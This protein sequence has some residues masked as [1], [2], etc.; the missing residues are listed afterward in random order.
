MRRLVVLVLTR[1]ADTAV[2]ALAAASREVEF[3]IGETAEAVAHAAPKAEAV[4]FQSG[5]SALLDCVL[6]MAPL[7]RWV[8]AAF[9]G[10]DRILSPYFVAHPAR[11]T[12]TR[13]VFG[14]ALAEFALGSMLYFAKDFA[15]MRKNQAKGVWAPFVVTMLEGKT[16]GVVG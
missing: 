9:S 12:N 7:V 4:F 16:L 11:L 5:D 15:R 3:V 6:A 1:K 2:A 13:G 10:V 8:H 14:R